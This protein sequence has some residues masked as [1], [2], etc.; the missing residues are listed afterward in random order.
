M[1]FKSKISAFS[2][3]F[4]FDL[5]AIS[6]TEPPNACLSCALITDVGSVGCLNIVDHD[7]RSAFLSMHFRFEHI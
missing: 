5:F 3:T 7:S 6:L 1:G 4:L 2:R